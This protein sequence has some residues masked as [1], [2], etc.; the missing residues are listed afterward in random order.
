MTGENREGSRSFDLSKVVGSPDVDAKVRINIS[1]R[2]EAIGPLKR[3]RGG[4]FPGSTPKVLVSNPTSGRGRYIL[5]YGNSFRTLPHGPVMFLPHIIFFPPMFFL[6]PAEGLSGLCPEYRF[7]AKP[8]GG[9]PHTLASFFHLIFY[10]PPA[11]F[12]GA[13]E[14]GRYRVAW[15]GF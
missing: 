15:G 7:Q 4:I 3:P 12:V 6:P 2:P 14:E 5:E 10:R 8:T 1:R 13:G 11:F 9:S